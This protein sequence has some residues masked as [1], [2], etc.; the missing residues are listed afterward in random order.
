MIV[1]VQV[2]DLSHENCKSSRVMRWWLSLLSSR[3]WCQVKS[4]T[5]TQVTP[6]S[7]SHCQCRIKNLSNLLSLQYKENNGKFAASNG[8]LKAK[9]F[10]APGPRWGLRLRPRYRLALPR[11]HKRLFLTPTFRYLPRPLDGILFQMEWL[12]AQRPKD[13]RLWLT[14]EADPVGR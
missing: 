6:R 14:W 13:V 1:M 3:F 10:P 5:Q 11:S 4:W 12:K 2:A 7:I 8:R 9:S